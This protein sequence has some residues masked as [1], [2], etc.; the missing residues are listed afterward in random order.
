MRVSPPP[1]SAAGPIAAFLLA[2]LLTAALV[3]DC[4]S[5]ASDDPDDTLWASIDKR[6]NSAMN[7]TPN[8]GWVL[9]WNGQLNVWGCLLV[10]TRVHSLRLMQEEGSE[11][12]ILTSGE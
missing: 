2:A 6:H 12:A 8:M 5:V 1:R 11:L 4:S 7:D 9:W 10:D 3:S